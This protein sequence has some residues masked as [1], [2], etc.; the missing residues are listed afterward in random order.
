MCSEAGVFRW[1]PATPRSRR[2][3]VFFASTRFPSEF[4]SALG[5]ESSVLH[6]WDL[7]PMPARERQQVIAGELER[8]LELHPEPMTSGHSMQ[9][10]RSTKRSR[11]LLALASRMPLETAA[12]ELRSA[13]FQ[14]EL[15]TTSSIALLGHVSNSQ[16]WSEPSDALAVMHIGA[17]RTVLS[18]LEGARIRLVRDLGIGLDARLLLGATGTDDATAAPDWDPLDQIT[19]GL[20]ELTQLASQVRRSLA[21]DA[22]QSP[23]S[24]ALRVLLAGDVTRAETMV[25][26]LRNELAVPVELLDLRPL[27]KASEAVLPSEHDAAVLALPLALASLA[28]ASDC[29]D[30]GGV[31]GLRNE[32]ARPDRPWIDR[33]RAACAIYTPTVLST[34]RLLEQECKT[35]E[36]R[37]VA[38]RTSLGRS[39]VPVEK[40]KPNPVLETLASD[41]SPGRFPCLVR[42]PSSFLERARSPP[43]RTLGQ[44][45]DPLRPRHDR[46]RLRSRQVEPW[47]ALIEAI[48]SDPSVQSLQ[49]GG[50]SGG[51]EAIALP[52]DVEIVRK[53]GP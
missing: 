24:P 19:M 22:E 31:R 15:L 17:D 29:I 30:L 48:A 25:A 11:I 43:R 36:A 8:E 52:L 1:S 23:A 16:P 20:S 34:N 10:D 40:R 38:L 37:S 9:T 6:S 5:T 32:L 33:D 12:K 13:G 4:G 53:G 44:R 51:N 21:Y 7:P 49:L 39:P 26:L 35:I 28:K 27:F 45:M 2:W 14:V 18:V 3:R 47:G 42:E 41:R 50:V 46:T